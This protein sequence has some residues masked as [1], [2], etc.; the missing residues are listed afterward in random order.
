[1]RV[2]ARYSLGA[3]AFFGVL[4]MLSGIADFIRWGTRRL[5]STFTD[6]ADASASP[7]WQ[8]CLSGVMAFMEYPEKEMLALCGAAGASVL[9][10]SHR[11]RTRAGRFGHV[12]VLSL[13][14]VVALL[15][16][17][18]KVVVSFFS[19]DG[20]VAQW[21]HLCVATALVLLAVT[22]CRL[23]CDDSQKPA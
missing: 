13:A 17:A 22:L 3:V 7:L 23:V 1:M 10:V 9:A 6:P 14:L 16:L 21:H 4:W 19:E 5:S 12:A 15:S 20:D 8:S 11:A 18:S 2:I